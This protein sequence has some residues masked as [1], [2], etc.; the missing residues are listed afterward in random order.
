MS[1]ELKDLV[2]AKIWYKDRFQLL[3]D[4]DLT[5]PYH[6]L[7]HHKRN[8]LITIAKYKKTIK[9]LSDLD[10]LQPYFN[11]QSS[12]LS[13]A[14]LLNTHMIYDIELKIAN[15]KIRW[16]VEKRL[17]PITG[18]K[19]TSN[20]ETWSHNDSLSKERVVSLR[21]KSAALDMLYE[22]LN[23]VRSTLANDILLDDHI[24]NNRYRQAV[25]Y[26]KN[27]TDNIEFL[28][29]YAKKMNTDLTNAAKHFIFCYN[30]DLMKITKTEEQLIV[31]EEDILAAENLE[32][33]Q[34]ILL[35][36]YF[37]NRCYL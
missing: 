4:F 7:I 28:E 25:C 34:E 29:I 9:L 30:E 18:N 15:P 5:S 17:I 19:R 27:D 10:D 3:Q 22:V 1:F 14:L 12:G 33:L 6:A 24:Y 23:S 20:T 16:A 36:W 26:L 21:L 8:R 11:I 32:S 37:Q 2:K 35:E 31:F 13:A